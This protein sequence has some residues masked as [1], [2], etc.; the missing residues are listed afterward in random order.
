[1]ITI[2]PA[3]EKDVPRITEIYNDAILTTTATFDTEEKCLEDRVDWF[4][5]HKSTHPILVALLNDLVIGFASLS[6][7]SDRCA[8]DSTAE[9]S[10]YVHKDYRKQ[11]VG[12]QLLEV[13][14]LEGEQV[15]LHTLIARITS[16][17]EQS[18]YLHERLGFHVVGTL[19]EVGKKFGNFHDVHMLQKVY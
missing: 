1:M 3:T 2:R 7:W 14:V 17:N 18:V 11:G 13:L 5:T 4:R 6:R 10:L 15:G 9:T 16:G 12:K 19:K 8:Y